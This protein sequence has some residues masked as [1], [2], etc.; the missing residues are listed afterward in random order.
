VERALAAGPTGAVDPFDPDDAELLDLDIDVADAAIRLYSRERAEVEIGERLALVRAARKGRINHTLKDAVS[1]LWHFVPHFLTQQQAVDLLL[2]AQRDAW[3]RSGGKDDGDYSGAMQTINHT[4]STYVPTQTRYGQWWV[5]VPDDEG[6]DESSPGDDVQVSPGKAPAVEATATDEDDPTEIDEWDAPSGSHSGSAVSMP[7]GASSGP[8]V[9]SDDT[10]DPADAAD[11]EAMLALRERRRIEKAAK[12]EAERRAEML[13]TERLRRE[14]RRQLDEEE[15][16]RRVDPERKARLLADFLDSG[17]LDEIEPLEPLIGGWLFKGT[18]AQ[19]FGPSGHYKSFIAA[20]MMRA[21]ATGEMWFGHETT[22]GRVAYMVAEGVQGFRARIRAIEEFRNLGRLANLTVVR[23][24]VQIGGPEWAEFIEIIREGDYS[25]VVIDTQART[26]VGRKENDNAEMGEVVAALDEL[27]EAT[28]VGVLMIHHSGKGEAED[29]RGASAIKGA[30]QTQIRV[31]KRKGM[32]VEVKAT[33]QKDHEEI[34]PYYLQ[35]EPF[36]DSLVVCAN[37]VADGMAPDRE[38]E[39]EA[40]QRRLVHAIDA[41]DITAMQTDPAIARVVAAVFGGGFGGSK[42][43]IRASYDDF[44]VRGGKDK[45][46]RNTFNSAWTRLEKSGALLKNPSADRYV[47]SAEGCKGVGVA[48]E[49]PA[50]VSEDEWEE[51]IADGSVDPEAG[52][53]GGSAWSDDAPPW[54]EADDIETP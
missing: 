43:E 53:G 40:E 17:Q 5:A 47:L 4:V 34:G 1:F 20:D 2:D 46:H 29:G 32:T 21:V 24:A 38:E 42:A 51:A 35:L 49:R 33:K 39:R 45:I 48:F 22:K 54:D 25:M 8:A 37:R 11:V 52:V 50:W 26:T 18:L 10:T 19:I 9:D 12:V 15:R 16:N 30:L 3:V 28:G 41:N 7:S 31:V 44:L 36:G 23:R 14:V 27:I 13:A 6:D